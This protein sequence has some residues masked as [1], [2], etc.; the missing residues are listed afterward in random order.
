MIG[1][2]SESESIKEISG[3]ADI[4]E[5][6]VIIKKSNVTTLNHTEKTKIIQNLTLLLCAY[7]AMRLWSKISNILIETFFKVTFQEVFRIL[8]PG[9][10]VLAFGGT[11]T[12][13]QLAKSLD[14]AGFEIRDTICWLYGQGFPKSY[15]IS[16]GIDKKAGK[17]REVIGIKNNTYDGAKRD[18][19][20]HKSPAETSN[21]GKWG[22]NET[23][24]GK[25]LTAPATLEA[26]LWEGWGTALKPS[27]EPI[28]VAMK[29]IDETYVNNALTHGVAGM[30]IDGGRVDYSN[31]TDNRIGTDAKAGGS[32]Q[33]LFGDYSNVADKNI[34][35]YKSDGRWPANVILDEVSA[36]ML[37]EQTGVLKSGK[38]SRDGHKRK[39]SLDYQ[40][41][42]NYA[43]RSEAAGELYGDSGGA[44]RFFYCAKASRKERNAGLDDLEDRPAFNYG[45]IKKSP[46]R[47]G[48]NTP[49]KNTHATVKPLALMEYLCKLTRTP[50]G[51]IVLDPFMGSG[52][53]GMACVNTDR[54]FIGIELV[55]EHYI[56]A[57]KR[58]EYTQKL[59]KGV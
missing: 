49:R 20:K 21:I 19:S 32:K 2:S 1:I 25:N 59:L 37:D 16:K 11:R 55:E 7:L 45:S 6:I 27:F 36:Q 18:P 5:N 38:E 22:L 4:V 44:S 51:G 43:D 47:T 29:P 35:M 28:I 8:K 57:R 54:D 9:G 41:N 34:Q 26:E 15:N 42:V 39:K 23:P 14:N 31:E 30:W 56:I 58:I 40:S 13:H 12:W 24:H 48:I 33:S 53:T 10:L 46:G 17:E 52:T 3:D 50:T